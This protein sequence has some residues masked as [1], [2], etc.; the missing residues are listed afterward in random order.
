MT[1]KIAL[2]AGAAVLAVAGAAYAGHLNI[3]AENATMDGNSVT[4]PSVQIDKN[5]FVVIHAVRDGQVIVPGSV[6]H[7]MVEAGDT[8]DVTV[9]IGDSAA[10]SYV[11]M[12]HY[13]TDGD[14]EYS[15]GEGMTE[16]DTPALNAEKKP[17]VK[18]V[19]SGM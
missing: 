9:E 14:G 8:S 1:R 11:A 15:F 12:L 7:T 10:D 4:F 6:G 19:K 18:P 3:D 16:V 5:G 17:Y 13:D 2:A